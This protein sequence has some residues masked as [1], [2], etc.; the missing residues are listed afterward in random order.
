FIVSGYYGTAGT[1]AY[2]STPRLF[3]VQTQDVFRKYSN[4]ALTSADVKFALEAEH[5]G[6]L[7]PRLPIDAGRLVLA[8]RQTLTIDTQLTTTPGEGGRGS[9]VDISGESF[10]IVS[11]L[12]GGGGDGSTIYLTADSLTNLNA[13]SLL[14]GGVRTDNADGTTSL[15]ITASSIEVDNDASHPLTGPEIILAV[16]GVKPDGTGASITLDD[17]ATIIASGKVDDPRSGDYLIDGS[18]G[19]TGQGAVLRVST[20]PERLV[21]RTNQQDAP[22]GDLSVGDAD[23][24]GNSLLLESSGDL[25]ASPDATIKADQLALGASQVTFTSNGDG[26]SGLVITPELQALLDQ[27]QHLTIRTPGDIAFSSGS[28]DF[29]NITFDTP[30]LVL[31][32]GNSVTLNADTLE[33]SNHQEAGAACDSEGAPVCGSGNLAINASEIDFGSGTVQTYGFGGSVTLAASTGIFAEGKKSVFDVGPADLNLETPLIADHAVAAVP[34]QPMLIPSLSLT[35]TGDVSISNPTGAA[36]ED[37]A[38][39]PGSSIS[40]DGNSINVTG[41]TIRSTAG[42]L[43]LTATDGITIGEGATLETPG[44]SHNFGDGADP[45][46][47]SAP[48]GLLQLTAENGDIDLQEGSTLSVGGGLGNAGTVE[49]QA[50]QGGVTFDGTLEANAPGAGGSFVLD[51]KD[52]FDL[53]TLEGITGNQFN[54]MIAIR[55][56]TGDLVL[57][58]GQT[59]K[60]SDIVLTADGGLVDIFG[61]LDASGAS[62]GTVSLFGLGGVTL[63]AGS[64]IDAH[65]NGF[66]PWSTMQAHGGDVMI[67]TDGDGVITVDDG[68]VIDV[69]A[70]D[71]GDRLVPMLHDGTMYYTYVPGDVGGTVHF[72][73]PVIEQDDGGDTVNVFYDGTINGARSIVLEGFK[74]F[75]LEKIAEDPN[76]VG[77]TINDKGQIVLDVGATGT[78]GQLNF[79]AD[80]GDGTLVQFVQDFDISAANGHLGDLTSSKVFHEDPGMELDYS[81]D[82]VLSSNWNL[83]AGVVDIAGAVAAGLMAELPTVDGKYYVLPGMEGKVFE[84]FTTMTYRVGGSVYGEPGILTI[85]AGGTLDIKGSITDGFFQFHDQNDPDYLNMGLG[86]GDKLYSAYLLT[87]CNGGDCGGIADWMMM[88]SLPTSYVTIPFGSTLGGLLINPAPYNPD[89]NTP[90]APGSLDGNTGDPL[91]SM[92]MFPLLTKAD[93][94]TQAVDSWSYRLV[95]GADL[96]GSA[97]G[98]PSVDPLRVVPGAGGSLIIEGEK[99]YSYAASKDGATSSFGDTLL[100]G[101]GS[102]SGLQLLSPDQWYQTFLAE[103]PGLDPDSYTFISFT[104][105]P[106]NVQEFLLDAANTFFADYPDQF[107]LFNSKGLMGVATT[108]SLAAKFMAQAVAPDFSQFKSDYKPPRPPIITTPTT[109]YARTL[110]R[111]GTGSINLA[112]AGNI[113]M[114]NGDLYRDLD[115][116]PCHGTQAQCPGYLQVG[117]TAVYTAGHLVDPSKQIIVDALTGLTASIDPAGF[118]LTNDFLSDPLIRGY[119]YGAGGD[120]STGGVGYSGVFIANPVYAEG[121]G[122]ISMSAGGDILGRRDVWDQARVAKY[123]DSTAGHSYA[124]MG[125]P[126]Q[127]WRSGILG[128]APNIRINPQLFTDGVGVLGGGDISID[129]GG[130]IDDL[131]VVNTTSL[132]TAAVDFGKARPP[133]LA[134]WTFGGG[135]I[136]IRAGGDLLGGR[137]DIGSGLANVSVQGNI[138]SAGDIALD[139]IND[140]VPNELRVRLSDADVNLSALGDIDIQGITALGVGGASS[141]ADKNLNEHGFYSAEAGIS[142]LADGNVTVDNTGADVLTE[143]DA[144]TKGTAVAV[145][146][147]SLTALSLTGDMVLGTGATGQARQILLYPSPIGELQL[148]A[149]DDIMPTV[150]AMSDSDPGLLPGAFSI[151][152]ATDHIV[153][154]DGFL[155]PGVLPDM[156]DIQRRALHNR[157]ATHLADNVPNRIYAGNDILDMIIFVPKQTRIG[158]GRDIVNMMFFGQ[159]LSPEDISRVAAGRDITATTQLV[160]PVVGVSESGAPIYGTPESAVQG[161]TFV[162]GGPG[163]F[164]LEAGRDMGPFLNSAVSDEFELNGATTDSAGRMAFGGGVLSVGNDWNPWLGKDGASLFI[165]FGVGKGQNFNG[166]RDYYLDPA[167]LPNLDG[168]LFVQVKDSNGNLVPDRNQPIYG[169]ILIKWMQGHAAD[170]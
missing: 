143:S 60:A 75:D 168:D 100:L 152:H 106:K 104:N 160:Q 29:N 116:N 158:A 112:A 26:I 3:T 2:D 113:D 33:L 67:G 24:E 121:G 32:D 51:E 159:N 154:G 68:A 47:V 85:R 169:P 163:A 64:L 38:G 101:I 62:G 20:G 44:Y 69:A 28:Y 165:E 71:T 137:L 70:R 17:G 66:G 109:A 31:L 52:A 76:F 129:A 72:R 22:G 170:A 7:P 80:Y 25:T 11:S 6:Q 130:N 58:A 16:D 162:I 149:G 103:N 42:L 65:A 53:A 98:T 134:L 79:L 4:I 92:Q 5:N 54:G 127:L 126:D 91:G 153:S 49:L 108:L 120:P 59:L 157:Q 93:G 161:N 87:G 74:E 102:G 146:P 140:P 150:I 145:Y 84:D 90:S 27:A 117:G 73:S 123:Y 164:F 122:N 138:G 12:P 61:T 57:G 8:P 97:L 56:A 10:D 111:S 13:A 21:T 132:T 48:G 155:F 96:T 118:V 105:A 135:N 40:I 37:V 41:T 115:G 81:G 156:T 39:M 167:N 19:M 43:H 131:S 124:W 107:Q 147:G 99:S 88:G 89:A 82:I 46:I 18:N 148:A 144:I 141:E 55:T 139:F 1:G 77:V 15:D 151:F 14:I 166:F 78:D 125:T 34:G 23:L 136:D 119:Q 36:A 50:A 95:G 110:V 45:Y 128:S 63:E 142:L 133:S 86:G 83:G 35:T 114:T 30:G 9:E 94:T